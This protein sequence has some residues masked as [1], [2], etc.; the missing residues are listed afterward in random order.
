MFFNVTIHNF[1]DKVFAPCFKCYV[2]LVFLCVCTYCMPMM[3]IKSYCGLFIADEELR[4][5]ADL[6]HS[7]ADASGPSSPNQDKPHKSLAEAAMAYQEEHLSPPKSQPARWLLS[8]VK[9]RREMFFR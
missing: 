4:T 5:L 6:A 2:A 8:Q 9:K 1:T 7:C 3:L